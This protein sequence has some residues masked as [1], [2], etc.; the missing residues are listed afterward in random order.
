MTP[1]LKR[2]LNTL[3][4]PICKHLIDIGARFGCVSNM[5]H[6]YVLIKDA[7]SENPILVEETVEI[8]DKKHKYKIT[9]IYENSK[10]T[11]AIGIFDID[12]EK[13]VQF[14][15]KKTV[16]SFDQDIFDFGNFKSDKAIQRIKTLLTFK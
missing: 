10:I 13:R 14:S 6:Y 1:E 12:L 4:C 11:T 5:E 2:L 3:R 7:H 15:F 8:Y 16:L 9:K